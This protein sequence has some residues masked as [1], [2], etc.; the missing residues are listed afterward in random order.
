[1]TTANDI[2]KQIKD[3]DV[4]FVDLRFTDRRA[5]CSM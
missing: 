5:S 2:L 3:D 1:M 4:K